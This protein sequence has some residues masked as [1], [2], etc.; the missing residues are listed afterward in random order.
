MHDHPAPEAPT[1]PQGVSEAD[2]KDPVC[3]MTVS[4]KS[5]HLLTHGGK[6]YWF[7]GSR[8]LGKFRDDPDQFIGKQAAK[9]A[10][11]PQQKAQSAEVVYTCPMHPEV[12]KMGPGS[13]PKCGMA[14][15]LF[16]VFVEDDE[17]VELKDMRW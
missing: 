8:C 16:G 3:G 17:N 9:E 13:C 5:P 14:L 11:T 15:E 10:K 6:S 2:T 12:R 1:E 4:T 7:C